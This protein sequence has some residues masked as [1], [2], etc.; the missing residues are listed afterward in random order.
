MISE[1][2]N[3]AGQEQQASDVPAA[4]AANMDQNAA[5]F[6]F[7]EAPGFGSRLRAVR[8]A[9]GLDLETCGHALRL[10]VRVLRQLENNEFDGIDYQ[11]YIGGYI[12]KYAS[13]LEIDDAEA[14]AAVARLRPS[15]PPLVATGG[16][17]HSRY[18]LDRYATAATYVVLTLVIAVPIVWLG[19]RG[20]LSHDMS[21]LAPLDA[22]P[23][24]QQDA[25]PQ[26]ASSGSVAA[27]LPAS[28]LAQ[29]TSPAPASASSALRTAEQ[30]L[31]ASMVPV[32]NLDSDTSIA[33]ATG[34]AAQ[35]AT[36]GSGSHSLTLDL[37]NSSWVEVVGK[38]G[39]RLE[40]GLLPAGTAKTYH[41]DQ[42]LEVRIGNATGAQVSLDGQPVTLDPY[43]RANVAH[44]RVDIQDGKAA[45]AGA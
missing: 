9:R 31:L 33:P 20:T 41:S 37:P 6:R 36:V 17:S 29:A 24:A 19:M 8:E 7:N 16:I 13:Y 3:P 28:A 18:L 40:Y 26:P 25:P 12:R 11:V 27:K 34:N 30:P 2:S 42:P 15:Q 45:P 43:R 38:D 21:H 23:V 14:E 35:P 32:P 10:P 1:Q 22:A 5:E 44:F 4:T 39:S